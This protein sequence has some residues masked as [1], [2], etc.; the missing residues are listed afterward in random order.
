MITLIIGTNNSGKSEL[1]ESLAVE[2]GT[3]RRY[4]LATM[5][6]FDETGRLRV[7]KHRKQREGKGFLT[8]E[9]ERNVREAT[10]FMEEPEKA[11]VLLECVSNLVGNELHGDPKWS[12]ADGTEDRLA[13]VFA[14][15]VAR[16]IRELAE[17]VCHLIIVTNEYERDDPGYDRQTIRYVDWLGRV[18]EKLREFSDSVYD[19]RKGK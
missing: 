16:D 13:E 1:A 18:N 2:A 3:G 4:Y 17:K 9:K 10:L 7:E 12:E 8:I 11:T 5:Q 19:L 14:E 6:V 15:S